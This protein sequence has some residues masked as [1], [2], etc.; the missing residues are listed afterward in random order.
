M[1][2]R[3]IKYAGH[4][5]RGSSGLSHLQVLESMLEGKMKVGASRKTWMK[6]DMCEWTGLDTYDKVKRAAE[7]RENWR[8]KIGKY[9]ERIKY[10]KVQRAAE[11]RDGNP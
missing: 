10:E 5:L 1:I 2:K 3:K 7:E 6:E 11:K 4:V 8:L 9:K